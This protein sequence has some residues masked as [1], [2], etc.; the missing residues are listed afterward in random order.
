MAISLLLLHPLTS[1]VSGSIL[2]ANFGSGK[3]ISSL[4]IGR[5]NFTI[6]SSTVGVN[7]GSN[8]WRISSV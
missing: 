7:S 5:E 8:P 1:P 4:C 6:L 2:A 3:S